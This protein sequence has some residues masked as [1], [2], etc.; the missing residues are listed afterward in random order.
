MAM[1]EPGEQCTVVFECTV[2][3][4]GGGVGYIPPLTSHNSVTIY[5]KTTVHCSP[6]SPLE[7]THPLTPLLAHKGKSST[8]HTEIQR[9]WGGGGGR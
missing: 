6:D 4:G 7:L 3:V 2:C 1:E 5:A 8:Y 9:T